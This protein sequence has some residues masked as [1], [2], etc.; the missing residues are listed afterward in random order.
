MRLHTIITV[1]LEKIFRRGR[2]YI[3]FIAVFI[4]ILLIM[5]GLKM[6]GQQLQDMITARLRDSFY[7]QGNLINGYLI[8]YTSLNTLWIHVPI[9]VVIVTGDLVSGE[10]SAG[11]F[12]MLMTRPLKRHLLITAKFICGLTYAT[13]LV[14]FLAMISL[15]LGLIMFGKGDLLVFVG[16]VNILPAEILISRFIM[17]F[18]Y[19]ILSMW[20]IAAL[21][22]VFS[23]IAD[24]SLVPILAS[25]AIIIV[26]TIISNFDLEIFNSIKPILFTTYLNDWQSF[27]A[28]ELD[29]NRILRASGVLLAHVFVFYVL[30]IWLFNRKDITT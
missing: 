10:S 14:L 4:I 23:V 11:T 20:T 16:A 17:S 13:L 30:S 25:M 5:I 15:G 22:F 21:S 7:F 8:T 3:S 2:S 28:Y 29:Y 27:F 19:G 24:N 9:L 26:F 1:E 6:E 18:A 12:R